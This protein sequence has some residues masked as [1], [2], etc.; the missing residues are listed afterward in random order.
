VEVIN[1]INGICSEAVLRYRSISGT[2]DNEIPEIF[3][4]SFAA[5]PLHDRFHCAVHVEYPYLK[6]AP[7]LTTDNSAELIREFG[8]LRADLVLFRSGLAPAV[9]EFKVLDEGC[10]L[11]AC[12]LD[13]DK[14]K[15]LARRCEIAGYV[16]ALICEKANEKLDIRIGK[17]EQQLNHQIQRGTPHAAF[18]EDWQWC[19]VCA[20]ITDA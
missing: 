7:A 3:L 5:S 1:A 2:P 15:R 6:L 13:A 12:A 11:A 4:G 14:V 16:A 20:R 17:L 8:G 9:I 19:F 10:S 18:H